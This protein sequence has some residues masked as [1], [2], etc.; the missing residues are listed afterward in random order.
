MSDVVLVKNVEKVFYIT[1]NRPDKLNALSIE[2]WHELG[3][4]FDEFE[5]SRSRTRLDLDDIFANGVPIEIYEACQQH[6]SDWHVIV[7]VGSYSLARRDLSALKKYKNL[8]IEIRE[9]TSVHDR[10]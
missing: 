4:A 10:A 1:I 3:K 6:L 8:D 9:T 5:K 7:S 2:V